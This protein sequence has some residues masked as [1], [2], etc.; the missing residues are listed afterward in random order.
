MGNVIKKIVAIS[1][2]LLTGFLLWSWL[3]KPVKPALAT[4]QLSQSS[5]PS[6]PLPRQETLS[7]PAQNNGLAVS[8]PL[9]FRPVSGPAPSSSD[10]ATAAAADSSIPVKHFIRRMAVSFPNLEVLRLAQPGASLS[11]PLFEGVQATGLVVLNRPE[12]RQNPFAVSG[13]VLQP[14]RGSFALVK[15]PRLGW[16]GMVL[17]STGNVA[18]DLE[19]DENG[20]LYLYEMPRGEVVCAPMPRHPDFIPASTSLAPLPRVPAG[21]FRSAREKAAWQAA[22]RA[23]VVSSPAVGQ[24]ATGPIP[25]LRSRPG[26]RG[27]LYL[28]FDGEVVTD[29]FWANGRTI[30]AEASG[31][32]TEQMTDIWKIM[33]EDFAPFQVNVTTV[34]ADY[35]SAP[36]GLRMR[37]IFTPTT[38]AMPGSGGVAYLGSFRWTGTTPCWSFNGTG[39]S[40]ASSR[41][42]RVASMTGSHELGHTFNL[43]HDG[44]TSQSGSSREYYGGHG[45]GATG[46]GPIM[47]APFD[48][49]VIHWS[50]GQYL[51]ANNQEDDVAII[52]GVFFGVGYVQDDYADGISSATT[53]PQSSRG[54][55]AAS[56]LIH[57]AS[58]R[59]VFR[60]ESGR[61]A[62][63]IAATG[64]TPE[65]NLDIKLELLNSAGTP[66]VTSDPTGTQGATLTYSSPAE[67]IY[68]LRVSSG[69][70]PDGSATGWTTYGSIGAYSLS[71]SFSSVVGYADNFANAA[72]LGSR[73]SF[74]GVEGSTVSATAEAGEPAHA[75][76]PAA[77]SLWWKW[78]APGAGTLQLD[79]KGSSFP[80]RL[81][82]YTGSSLSALRVLSS[83][84]RIHPYF[85][86]SQVRFSFSRGTTYY[87]AVDGVG[88]ASGSVVLNGAAVMPRGPAHDNFGS[89]QTLSGTAATYRG[90]SFNATREEGEPQHFQQNTNNTL[91]Y[92]GF[93][94][95]WHRWTAPA[96]GTYTVF[97]D[98]S[99]FDTLLG[100]YTGDE[101]GSL[102]KVAANDNAFSTVRWSRVRFNATA[103]TTY[104]IA[105]DGVRRQG[106]SYVLTLRP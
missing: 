103:G 87:V 5:L 21:G 39:Q 60:M 36:Q 82:V 102:T 31:L 56:G 15:D 3:E 7:P 93:C 13:E 80:T 105:V 33:A 85:N 41:A 78:T 30:R 106:G 50:R 27:V 104:F 55:V 43:R 34:E 61:G 32:S 44:D 63:T 23:A 67:A 25:I 51:N 11:L 89:A 9:A 75:G 40:A 101:I 83:G 81:A 86:H 91:G 14:F 92:S 53:L 58:D 62:I 97:T 94:S 52:S 2:V 12:D 18:Y 49:Q 22:M 46:W 73:T 38:D 35:T 37:N 54:V 26:A 19:E 10:A 4:P 42:V 64:A 48:R 47:G 100:V 70:E 29:P 8:P 76:T 98:G 24:R 79:T 65:A 68:Y 17:P 57:A 88:G 16:R 6:D 77:K 1:L 66:I 74:S 84:A 99:T 20:Q 45:S 28:D 72:S 95:V 59:D 69:A 90:S 96:S 71:G